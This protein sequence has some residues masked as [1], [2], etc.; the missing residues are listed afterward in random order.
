MAGQSGVFTVIL[1][2]A[3]VVTDLLKRPLGV[4]KVQCYVVMG[5][6]FKLLLK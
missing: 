1:T 2:Q 4:S 5:I 6:R 3:F